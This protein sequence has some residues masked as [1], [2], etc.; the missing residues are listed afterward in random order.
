MMKTDSRGLA[1]SG[2]DDFAVARYDAAI[3][4]F[5]SYV[6]D[7]I[8]VIDEALTTSPAFVAGHL[9]KANVLYTLAERQFVPM[10]AAALDAAKAHAR[11][12]NDRERLMIDATGKLV[13]G[14][15][16]RAAQAYDRVLVDYPRDALA[17]QVGHLMDFFR[18]DALNLR[19]R[20]SR[21]LP[22]WDA[23]VP[24]YSYVLGMHAFGLEEMNQYAEAE[25]TVRKALALQPKDGW[26]VHALV[27]VMEMQGRI[28]EG[29][30]FLVSREHDWAPDN[31][32]AYHNFWHLALFHIDSGR[33]DRALALYDASI[34]P[35]PATY[36]LSLLDATA[37]L[38]RLT[39]EGVDV[40]ER[41]SG[42]ADEWAQRIEGEAGFYAFNDFHA[43]MA[44]AATGR[45]A[46][47]SQLTA[48]MREVAASDSVNA[49]M[50]REV[51]L[52]LVQGF[53]AFARGR[54][55]EAVEALEPVRDIANR[56]GG[57]H[58]Q[59][60]VITLTIIEAALR[61]GDHGRAAHYIAERLVHKPGS[62]W[63]P[64]L[65]LRA[66]AAPRLPAAA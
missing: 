21:V 57:S 49:A 5:Q 42:V 60:D 59:R 32:F 51:G 8:G 41:F 16:H 13:A 61:S 15:W 40:G 44:F 3:G 62:A 36:I 22:Q 47:L 50:T 39:L 52:P 19:N 4:H 25:A 18:G 2:A 38:W 24:G 48:R 45:D 26:A 23:S 64:R 27:H 17:L 37:L 6:G 35:E 54:Y 43:A 65:A 31:A 10:A 53:G 12:A 63:G 33:H 20:V 7:P 56:F 11:T 66:Q 46:E 30:E 34:H 58:A 29:I 14:D 1:L 9:L 55:A 28:G